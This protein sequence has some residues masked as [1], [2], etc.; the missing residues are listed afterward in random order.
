MPQPIAT[1]RGVDYLSATGAAELL[2]L[3]L[4]AFLQLAKASGH[5]PEGTLR[6]V[7]PPTIDIWSLPLV[8]AIGLDH[9][10]AQQLVRD[11]HAR[12][13]SE[14]AAKHHGKKVAADYISEKVTVEL[15]HGIVF[16]EIKGWII[17]V[18][19]TNFS[20]NAVDSLQE[21]IEWCEENG[22]PY[23]LIEA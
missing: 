10:T 19:G 14:E 5:K 22:L 8:D 11:R 2:G 21:A 18:K 9:P 1:V 12:A 20:L 13:I 6:W 3:S 23:E 4:D 15:Q 7:D 17:K 16:G